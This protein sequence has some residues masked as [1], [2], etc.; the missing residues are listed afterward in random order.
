MI[1]NAY[2]IYRNLGNIVAKASFHFATGATY[3]LILVNAR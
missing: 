1:I 3:L 2:E